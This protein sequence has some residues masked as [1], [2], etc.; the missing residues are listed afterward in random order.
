MG[1]MAEGVKKSDPNGSTE[2]L[3][4]EQNSHEWKANKD[5]RSE[6]SRQMCS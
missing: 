5:S 4:K 1:N 6:R 2:N 3:L